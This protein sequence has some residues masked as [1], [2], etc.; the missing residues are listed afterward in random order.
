[1]KNSNQNNMIEIEHKVVEKVQITYAQFDKL[2]KELVKILLPKKHEYS[3]IHGLP[4]GGLSIAVHLSH[5]LQLPLMMN[6]TQ[7]SKEFPN[8]KLL[9]VDDIIDTGRTFERFL[10]IARLKNIKFETAVLYYKPQSN[11]YPTYYLRETEDWICFPW[12]VFEERPN[13]E[14]YEHLGG[15]IDSTDTDLDLNIL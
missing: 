2:M 3:C 11:Y 5:H 9:V 6:V 8:G 4:R 13:R 12:E 10:E 14:K 15:S 7:F 1:M